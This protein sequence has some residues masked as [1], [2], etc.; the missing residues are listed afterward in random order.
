M[1]LT[2]S[3]IRPLAV[4]TDI[5]SI[6]GTARRRWWI[7]PIVFLLVG[8]GVLLQDPKTSVQPSYF[9]L[10]RNYQVVD[11]TAALTLLGLPGDLLLPLP[12]LDTQ[13]AQLIE[14]SEFKGISTRYPTVSLNIQRV[15]PQLAL[16]AQ[17]NDEPIVTLRGRTDPVLSLICTESRFTSCNLALDALQE[18]VTRNHELAL[19]RGRESLAKSV[20]ELQS[21]ANQNVSLK[22]RLEVVEFGL[23]ALATQPLTSLVLIK[24]F[25][26]EEDETTVTE[27]S[28]YRFVFA[29]TFVLLV[30]L[31]LQWSVFDKTIYGVRRIARTLG[32]NS[33]LARIRDASDEA[34]IAAVSASLS[35]LV[36][37]GQSLR[38]VTAPGVDSDLLNTITAKCKVPFT[39][40]DASA[41]N[42]DQMTSASSVTLLIAQRGSTSMVKLAQLSEMVS[43]SNGA[44]PVVLLLG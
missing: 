20:E 6:L 30:L 18:L 44:Q 29:L 12:S 23:R 8:T 35:R 4:D 39:L 37:P 25:N 3:S 27:S 40:I 22:E 13:L 9:R 11:N 1:L 15:S 34:T 7:A 28:N 38:L 32:V 14:S 33:V 24:E 17:E 31:L 19:E 5:E 16:Q 41:L 36:G 42:Q 26:A 21:Q 10:D 43:I 2:H